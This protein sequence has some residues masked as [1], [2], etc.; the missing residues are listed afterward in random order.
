MIHDFA[1]FER[2][3]EVMCKP[4]YKSYFRAIPW[5]KITMDRAYSHEWLVM[6]T[7]PRRDLM[8]VYGPSGSGKSFLA[9][10]AGVAVARG[11]EFFGKQTRRGGVIYI[12][13]EGQGGFEKRLVGYKMHYGIPFDEPLPF[14]L[15]PSRINLFQRSNG[16]FAK[17]MEEIGHWRD[18]FFLHHSLELELVVVDTLAASSSGADE[19][20]FKDM[21]FVL[22]A[23]QQ[24]KE[25]FNTGVMFVHHTN[26]SGSK[27]RGHSSVKAN[28]ETTVSIEED[29]QSHVRTATIKKQKDGEGGV[30]FNFALKSVEVGRRIE[31]GGA[32]TTCVVVPTD[33]RGGAER[34]WAPTLRESAFLLAMRRAMDQNA[35]GRESAIAAAVDS[36][37]K[38]IIRNLPQS[39]VSFVLWE[40][41]KTAYKSIAPDPD[42]EKAIRR[43]LQNSGNTLHRAHVIG[44]VNPVIWRTGRLV[45]DD[46]LPTE[47]AQE[48]SPPPA[49]V[50]TWDVPF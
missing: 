4:K 29:Q 44:R 5:E 24:I 45:R 35:I 31:D 48:P 19:N 36:A 18:Q 26:A 14:I 50:D 25:S 47:I 1:T 2:I 11:T 3:T 32:I 30:K 16:E 13:G 38:D 23:G 21:S 15:L 7:L 22:D 49:Q 28:L 40:H 33:A 27:E 6:D 12:A 41:F 9:E 42:D 8:M 37:S 20:S 43:D 17:L 10:H 39:I 46:Y 34:R